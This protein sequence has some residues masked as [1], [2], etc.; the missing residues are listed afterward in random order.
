MYLIK[1]VC[2]SGTNVGQVFNMLRFNIFYTSKYVIFSVCEVRCSQGVILY[3]S[4]LP[5]CWPL[6]ISSYSWG[7]L[8]LTKVS[9]SSYLC[10]IV[11]DR[12]TCPVFTMKST[13]VRT[14]KCKCT[15]CKMCKTHSTH[16]SWSKTLRCKCL[17][18]DRPE[19]SSGVKFGRPQYPEIIP[20]AVVKTAW[21]SEEVQLLS[22][23]S[24]RSE[25]SAYSLL[26]RIMFVFHF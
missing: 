21:Y 19:C 26:F 20:C 3:W 24:V 11:S 17:N 23:S 14:V 4:Y 13:N 2:S 8:A 25:S 18:H 6:T 15:A 12:A 7:S 1:C 22:A 16:Q 5:F 10:K 9:V